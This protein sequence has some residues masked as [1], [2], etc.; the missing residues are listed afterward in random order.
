MGGKYPKFNKEYLW[1]HGADLNH[2]NT[3]DVKYLQV[4][5]GTKIFEKCY[6]SMYFFK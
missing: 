1:N 2:V 6:I 4:F 3:I 5:Y